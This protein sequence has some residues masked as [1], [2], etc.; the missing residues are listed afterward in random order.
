MREILNF[1]IEANKLNEVSRTGW[2]LRKVQNPET[3]AEH[4]F[5]MAIMSWL[6]AASK[7]LNVKRAI[8]IALSHDLCEVYAG[9][10]TPNLYYRLPKSG[11]ARK[12]ILMKWARLSKKEKE[13]IEKVKFKKEKEGLL[14]LIKNMPPSIKRD[15]F[16]CWLDFE[17]GLSKE[18]KFVNQIN[19]IETL[20]QSIKYFGTENV[21]EMTTWWEWVEEMVDDPLLFEFTEAIHK[22]FYGKQTKT[23]KTLENILDFVV[24][25]GEL[26][27]MPRF[28]W[29][30]RGI[31]NPQTVAGHIFSVTLAAWI[32]AFL[33]N[34]LNMGKLLKIALC[35]DLSAVYTRDITSYDEIL[36]GENKI[37]KKEVLKRGL[38]LS[39]EEKE[40][41]FLKDYQEEKRS[42]EKLTFKLNQPLKKE[43][44]QLWQEYHTRSSSE[45]KFLSQ[46]N[47]A[48]ILLQ[49]LLY[50]KKY[51][52]FSAVPFWEWAFE[53]SDDPLILDFLE[54]MKAK[55]Y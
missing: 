54:T 23:A 42:I 18:G 14:R 2:I 50:E 1:L 4:S 46:L 53:V 37:N 24:T 8:K 48:V 33:K 19:R 43:I 39:K 55:F 35:H 21:K 36:R 44:I 20:V 9:D 7:N 30:F 15:I 40:S 47:T 41:I 38:R 27:G 5:G 16:S 11:K 26:K 10:I 17:R 6:L 22:K 34:G 29:K 3:I 13:K 28:Y 49:G 45:G 52:K 51:K 12:K 25:T 31:K 32:F